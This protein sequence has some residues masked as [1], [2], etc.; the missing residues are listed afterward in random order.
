MYFC[1]IDG[2][3]N[4]IVILTDTYNGFILNFQTERSE[5]TV[6]TQIRLSV[7]DLHCLPFLLHLLEALLLRRRGSSVV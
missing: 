1:A 7:Q 2:I 4:F 5:P 3:Q 6:Q